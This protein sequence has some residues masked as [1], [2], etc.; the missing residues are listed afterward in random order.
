M[1]NLW[2]RLLTKR[3][4]I[5]AHDQKGLIVSASRSRSQLSEPWEADVGL[6]L[7]AGER[8]P[9]LCYQWR[10][11]ELFESSTQQMGAYRSANGVDCLHR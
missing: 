4:W 2:N 8:S 6:R 5:V 11:V 1:S 7:D 3:M 10:S 9:M